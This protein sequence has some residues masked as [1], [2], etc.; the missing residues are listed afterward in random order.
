MD[1]THVK[2]WDKIIQKVI[3]RSGQNFLGRHS[4]SLGQ[5]A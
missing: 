5:S 1:L 3:E 4:I 2:L